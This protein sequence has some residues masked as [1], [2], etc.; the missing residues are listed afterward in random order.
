MNILLRIY[1]L[2]Q[3]LVKQAKQSWKSKSSRPGLIVFG[4]VSRSIKSIFNIE[5]KMIICIF[6]LWKYKKNL[7]C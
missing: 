1:E 3:R 2:F 4:V 7:K 5:T 6:N